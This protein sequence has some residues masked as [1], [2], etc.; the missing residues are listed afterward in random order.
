MMDGVAELMFDQLGPAQI[1][2]QSQF[3]GETHT[4][5]DLNRLV[6]DEPRHLAAIG[7][8][9]RRCT[10]PIGVVLGRCPKGIVGDGP[11]GFDRD[12]HVGAAVLN[13]LEGSN[14]APELFAGLGIFD[15]TVEHSTGNADQ[16]ASMDDRA[17]IEQPV[18]CGARICATQQRVIAEHDVSQPNSSQPG[19]RIDRIVR[20]D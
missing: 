9:H 18:K 3:P 12:R 7:L 2:M 1:A 13:R 5:M 6:A 17:D 11:T 20:L 16:Q 14:R 10:R 19:G 4:A 15:R 8:C